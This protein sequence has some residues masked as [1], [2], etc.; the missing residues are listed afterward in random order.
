MYVNVTLAFTLLSFCWKSTL[1][2]CELL[3]LL[4]SSTHVPIQGQLLFLHA[5]I[6]AEV[7]L[8]LCFCCPFP[9]LFGSQFGACLAQKHVVLETWN[10]I[11]PLLQYKKTCNKFVE[12]KVLS[13]RSFEV[14]VRLPAQ[15]NSEHVFF[16]L[17]RTF[18]LSLQFLFMQLLPFYTL[19]TT[20]C[21][22]ILKIN[23]CFLE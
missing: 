23:S 20:D 7:A 21:L 17:K 16:I 19:A 22:H 14:F 1:N 3:S 2:N 6:T 12:F 13:W 18:S 9:V 10:L 8:I 5:T 11:F 15:L 4:F